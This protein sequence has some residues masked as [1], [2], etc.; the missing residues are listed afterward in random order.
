MRKARA[1]AKIQPVIPAVGRAKYRFHQIWFALQNSVEFT[2]HICIAA[3]AIQIDKFMRIFLQI[4]QFIKSLPFQ[5]RTVDL[6]LDAVPNDRDAIVTFGNNIGAAAVLHHLIQRL[7]VTLFRQRRA[8][9]SKK[10]R[11]QFERTDHL[12]NAAFFRLPGS[13]HEQRDAEHILKQATAFS[14]KAV[15]AHHLAMIGR[16]DY[17]QIRAEFLPRRTE[18]FSDLFVYERNVAKIAPPPALPVFLAIILL[19]AVFGFLT[20]LRGSGTVVAAVMVFAFVVPFVL[21]ENTAAHLRG[22]DSVGITSRRIDRIMR[23]RKADPNKVRATTVTVFNILDGATAR[24]CVRMHL[25]FKRKIIVPVILRIDMRLVPAG[26]EHVLFSQRFRIIVI[27][28]K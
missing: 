20:S 26:R 14:P 7:S 3:V 5:S 18:D 21:T 8:A 12:R 15:V 24:P 22:I 11:K 10:R 6:K 19:R 2:L 1:V 4:I 9:R 13:L 25:R 17:H 28:P 16:K 27:V 23:P